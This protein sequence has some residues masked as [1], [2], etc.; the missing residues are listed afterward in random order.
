M[1]AVTTNTHPQ[2]G[3][4]LF[5]PAFWL[6]SINR[7]H[8]FSCV[9]VEQILYAFLKHRKNMSAFK[10]FLQY[11]ATGPDTASCQDYERYEFVQCLSEETQI[12]N[13]FTHCKLQPHKLS[14]QTLATRLSSCY[15]FWILFDNMTNDS[16]ICRLENS[17]SKTASIQRKRFSLSV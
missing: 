4:S 10:P 14:H 17:V 9:G 16:W 7:Y 13:V 6:T 11:F 15:E 5:K 12:I 3:F 8:G 2:M 1:I